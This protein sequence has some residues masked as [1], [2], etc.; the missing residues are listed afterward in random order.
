MSRPRSQTASAAVP[1][2]A[3]IESLEP[4]QLLAAT[5]SAALD[6]AGLLRVEGTRSADEIVVSRYLGKGDVLR[7]Q[8]HVNGRELANVRQRDVNGIR[9]LGGLGNDRIKADATMGGFTIGEKQEQPTFPDGIAVTDAFA[10]GRVT[11][12]VHHDI[13]L[14]DDR[15]DWKLVLSGPTGAVPGDFYRDAE[16]PM[17]LFGGAGEDSIVGGA[18]DDVIDGGS[19]DDS[20][21]GGLG[22]D[23]ILGQNDDDDLY[24]GGG[25]DTLT[26]GEGNDSLTA[27]DAFAFLDATGRLKLVTDAAAAGLQVVF[28]P[29]IFDAGGG[30][31]NNG[32]DSLT[33]GDGKDTFR[34]SEERSEITDLTGAD[35]LI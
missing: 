18:G 20:L 3:P 10:G 15:G 13:K 33:G 9:I 4:R 19:G 27:D 11:P 34:K 12:V 17:T 5:G 24:G 1:S 23:R 2:S 25:A 28:T 6:A 26:G 30:L 35:R 32:V 31:T 16:I 14:T 7:L 21:G 29:V 22:D 8:V